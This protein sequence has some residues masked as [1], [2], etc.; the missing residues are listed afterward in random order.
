MA[1]DDEFHHVL[2]RLGKHKLGGSCL[3][4]SKL[5]DVDVATLEELILRSWQLVQERY[6]PLD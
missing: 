1:K 2:T 5:E 3:Y 4:V 6:G